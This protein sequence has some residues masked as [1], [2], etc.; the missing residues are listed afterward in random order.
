MKADSVSSL[1]CDTCDF[2]YYML[3]VST[4]DQAVGG[5]INMCVEKCEDFG[6]NWVANKETMRCEY[7]G[8]TCTLCSP[9]YGCLA[10]Y[11][12]DR[13]FKYVDSSQYPAG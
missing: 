2:G 8:P 5:K 10:D 12:W 11:K 13:A 4:E 6:Y 9:K 7:C 3:N 1:Q